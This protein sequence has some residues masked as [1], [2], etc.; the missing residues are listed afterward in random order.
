MRGPQA[1]LDAAIAAKPGTA[2]QILQWP[3]AAGDPAIV[4]VAP[5]GARGAQASTLLVDP[6]SLAI[7]DV[8]E[9][10]RSSFMRTVHDI[11]GSMLVGGREGRSF[12]GWLGVGML[13]LGITGIVLWWPR[14]NRWKDAYGVKKGATGW[15]FYRQLHG[16]AGIT[17][18]VLFI[19]LSFTG[20][21]IAFPQTISAL[22]EG[23]TRV[24]VQGPGTPQI[25]VRP[26]EGAT[27]IKADQALNLARAAAPDA[28]PVFMFLPQGAD[29][30]IRVNLL[31]AGAASGAPSLSVAVD[32]Y[33]GEVVNVRDPWAGDLG[34]DVMTWQRPLHT[35]RG[36]SELYKFAI[37]LVGLLPPLFAVTGM[38]MWWVKRR[39]RGVA[40]GRHGAMEGVPAE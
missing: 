14:G 21:A 27:P 8:R 24:A 36:T 7:L 28:R 6:A 5:P 31:H 22:A 38:L 39:A 3:Q 16:T 34:D 18:W 19:I 20:I 25:R 1:I 23:P 40:R 11:H 4:R 35:G 26:V 29:Q 13:A 15:L 12:V 37:F 17:A 2:A 33:R 9:G 30:P 32:P 10:F